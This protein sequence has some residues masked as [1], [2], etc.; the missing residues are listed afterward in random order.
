MAV[1]VAP[2]DTQPV[3]EMLHRIISLPN[4]MQTPGML[5]EPQVAIS[6]WPAVINNV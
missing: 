5:E 2:G 1:L 3:K 4:A 6:I